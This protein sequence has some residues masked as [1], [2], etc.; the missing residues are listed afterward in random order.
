MKPPKDKHPE[1]KPLTVPQQ[2]HIGR[3][4]E[5]HRDAILEKIRRTR[6]DDDH[7][8]DLLKMLKPI[9]NIEKVV[10]DSA[11]L[12]TYSTTF[13]L[14]SLSVEDVFTLDVIKRAEAEYRKRVNKFNEVKQQAE[15]TITT[16]ANSALDDV[17][18]GG[19]GVAAM[20]E[21]LKKLDEALV[22]FTK[23]VKPLG[24]ELAE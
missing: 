7:D 12:Y 10:Q 19:G 4:I 15:Q 23:A 18:I 2:K 5:E 9:I 6:R 14:K 1:A 22:K 3:R 21:Q 13:T 16:T 24:A 17:I 11:R 20:E 8:K